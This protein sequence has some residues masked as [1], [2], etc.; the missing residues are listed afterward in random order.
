M[1]GSL[2]GPACGFPLFLHVFGATVLV[3]AILT[4]TILTWVSLRRPLEQAQLLRRLAFMTLLLV[5]W[6][7]WL[8]M[9]IAGQWVL[10]LD[11]YSG[12]EAIAPGWL[13]VGF[14]V[15]DVGVLVLLISTILAWF[16][17][18]RTR[19]ETPKPLTAPIFAGLT[20]LYLAALAIAWFAM[21]AKPGA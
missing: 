14:I 21:S 4:V 2:C 5:G 1:T 10:S 18:R 8:A 15:G 7:S 16:A 3:G 6:P 12:V 17:Y 20:T 11:I 13:T 9:R 19:A